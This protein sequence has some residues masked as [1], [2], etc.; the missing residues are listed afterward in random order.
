MEGQKP[1]HMKR[2]RV[3]LMVVKFMSP[4]PTSAC[5]MWASKTAFFSLC[6]LHVVKDTTNKMKQTHPGT[7]D[8]F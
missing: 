7:S 4:N 1:A 3:K 5:R 8:A 6:G 2:E